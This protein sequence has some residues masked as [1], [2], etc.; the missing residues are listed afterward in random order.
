MINHGIRAN[1]KKVFVCNLSQFTK[2]SS[3]STRKNY[4]TQ[5]HKTSFPIKSKKPLDAFRNKTNE[6]VEAGL[7][8][9]EIASW[10]FEV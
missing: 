3:F 4:A 9:A 5:V 10:E 8:I 1:R 7:V 2:A 6:K